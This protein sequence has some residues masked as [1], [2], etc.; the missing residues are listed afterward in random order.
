MEGTGLV[1]M[2]IKEALL[3]SVILIA[4]CSSTLPE[5]K[6]NISTESMENICKRNG[7]AYEHDT[8]DN[9]VRCIFSDG[10]SCDVLDYYTGDCTQRKKG[11]LR[12]LEITYEG[13][14]KTISAITV[15]IGYDINEARPLFKD[16]SESFLKLPNIQI[17]QENRLSGP[18][19]VAASATRESMLFAAMDK[20][21]MN[22]AGLIARL[23]IATTDSVTPDDFMITDVSV[24]GM[25]GD[26]IGN[27]EEFSI[28]IS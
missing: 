1:L 4:G 22:I 7:L 21:G 17:V 9:T 15:N 11:Q 2:G 26:E 28:S 14:P 6:I 18:E 13:E 24:T 5:N 8:E 23:P 16:S 27:P 12:N 3:L 25:Q 10:S 19:I 20:K